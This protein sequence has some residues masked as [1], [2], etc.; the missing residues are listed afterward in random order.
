MRSGK[1]MTPS[2]KWQPI[3]CHIMATDRLRQGGDKHHRSAPR[4]SCGSRPTCPRS[5]GPTASGRGPARVVSELLCH[6][7]DEA[8]QLLRAAAGAPVD[9]RVVAR[10]L[11]DTEATPLALIEVGAEF[12]AEELAGQACLPGPMPLTRRVADRFL[13]QVAG[14]EPGT[15]AFLL[16]AAAEVGGDRA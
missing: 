8:G 5:C 16:L 2:S 13:R 1:A 10:I 15:L 6:P 7:A 12:T 9:D 11:A 3:G 4:M 14:L